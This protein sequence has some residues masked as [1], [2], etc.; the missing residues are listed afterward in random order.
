MRTQK[1]TSEALNF[2]NRIHKLRERIREQLAKGT[3]PQKLAMTVAGG[4]I[5]G[6]F[7]I[8]GATSLLCI[9]AAFAF[10]LNHVFIQ[11]VN[12]T[13][14]PLQVVL[15][16]PFLKAGNHFFQLNGHAVNY[17]HL[18]QTFKTD[19]LAALGEFGAII[20]SA[21]LLWAVI[22]LPLSFLLYRSSLKYL[23]RV[24]VKI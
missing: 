24:R 1:K 18:F 12:Y 6:L 16:I 22:A 11:V 8:I 17:H 4:I 7:P 19:T 14:Y 21:I 3:S 5:L 10:R 2:N 13:V 20:L 23:K 15:F 9:G